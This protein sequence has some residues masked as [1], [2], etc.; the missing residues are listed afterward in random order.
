MRSAQRVRRVP[1]LR[2]EGHLE[3]DPLDAAA[4]GILLRAGHLGV[5]DPELAPPHGVHPRGP[6]GPERVVPRLPGVRRHVPRPARRDE[7]DHIGQ[8]F[9][10]LL[11]GDEAE[12]AHPPGHRLRGGAAVGRVQV[13]G[14]G[15]AV[16]GRGHPH[17][18]VVVLPFGRRPDLDGPPSRV[19][20]GVRPGAEPEEESV[21]ERSNER[22]A[23]RHVPGEGLAGALLRPVRP[24]RSSLRG[25]GRERHRLGGVR[26]DGCPHPGGGSREPPQKR[27][28]RRQDQRG[29][30][31]S[32][33]ARRASPDVAPPG[34][35][36]EDR[37]S[38]TSRR[39]CGGLR[40][41]QSGPRG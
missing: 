38:R 25:L 33:A 26:L 19:R 13:P 4:G 40:R 9:V 29:A 30:G 7:A 1:S 14:V 35:V 28:H 22:L 5:G 36:R 8:L 20:R 24:K 18:V 39:S 32:D 27:G 12:G 34:S 15:E 37:G 21:P 3:G 11:R 31:R 23:V 16:G 10:L 17:E 2:T 41:G 6:S